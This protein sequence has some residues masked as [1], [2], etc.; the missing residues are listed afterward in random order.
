M[1]RQ[2]QALVIQNIKKTRTDLN[3]SRDRTDAAKRIVHWIIKHHASPSSLQKL[4]TYVLDLLAG[5][6][7]FSHRESWI[8][9]IYVHR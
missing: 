5:I 4:T 9:S 2:R 8:Q 6:Q 1:P 3:E 7:M